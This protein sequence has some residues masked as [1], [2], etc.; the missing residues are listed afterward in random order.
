M[1]SPRRNGVDSKRSCQTK[2]ETRLISH[3]PDRARSRVRGRERRI[4]WAN[5]RK[6]CRR[7]APNK[8]SA[9]LRMRTLRGVH[10]ARTRSAR[11]LDAKVQP[12]LKITSGALWKDDISRAKAQRKPFRNAVALCAFARE[13]FIVY[14]TAASVI[15]NPLS[16]IA[17]ASRNSS[18]VIQSG[19]FVKNVFHRTR[20]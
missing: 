19:G 7:Q 8:T 6:C 15:S 17:N 13:I 14:E 3:P 20:V 16:M 18:S 5:D 4:N 9:P 2:I 10:R 12:A 1:Q 11:K